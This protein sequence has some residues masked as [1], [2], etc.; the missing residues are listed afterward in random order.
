MNR[1]VINSRDF[2]MLRKLKDMLA[3]FNRPNVM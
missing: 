3:Y 2:M 1:K